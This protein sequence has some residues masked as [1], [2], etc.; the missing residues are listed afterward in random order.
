[1]DVELTFR[2]ERERETLA[3]IMMKNKKKCQQLI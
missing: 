3:L 2:S 1:M